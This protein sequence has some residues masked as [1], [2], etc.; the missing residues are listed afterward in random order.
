MWSVVSLVLRIGAVAWAALVGLGAALIAAGLINPLPKFEGTVWVISLI[1][2]GVDNV[3]TLIVRGSRRRRGRR[4]D[5][6]EDA[7]MVALLQIV[8]ET[9]QLHLEDLGANAYVVSGRDSKRLHRVARLRPGRYP[10]E[11]GVAWGSGKGMVGACL[12]QK[13]RVYRNWYAVAKKYGNTD[14]SPEAFEKIPVNTRCGFTYEEFVSIVGKY[15]E[16]LAEPIW[17]LRNDGRIL[18]V[19]TVDR[20]YRSG[21]SEYTPLLDKRATHESAG[22]AA[23]VV[24][25]IVRPKAS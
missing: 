24:S 11:S 13:K 7:L 10:Q 3:G 14:I 22:L 19:L 25:R 23:S 16:V 5:R 9:P 8:R 4:M 18:G 21:E 1:I 2:L 15:S 12:D 17:D 20:A 6:L